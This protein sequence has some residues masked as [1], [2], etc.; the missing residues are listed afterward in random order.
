MH[1]L[2]QY[3]GNVT[4]TW[5]ADVCDGD[6]GSHTGCY[7]CRGKTYMACT[8]HQY[9]G[10]FHTRYT[11]HQYTLSALRTLQK[12]GTFL[13]GHTAGNFAHWYKKRQRT[14]GLLYGLVSQTHTSRFHHG[15][16]Q[17]GIGC[18]MKIREEQLV[19]FDQVV[20]RLNG[21]LHFYDHFSLGIYVGDCRQN[22]CTYGCVF[23]VRKTA[24]DAS[25]LLN[26]HYVSTLY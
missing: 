15:I 8:Q 24:V 20:F 19:L 16:E 11:T 22:F 7:Q 17:W 2:G 10:G 12:S 25:S 5:Q 1:I 6:I 14:V 26:I 9:L 23:I 3:I 13:Y 21:F 18:K 4:Q